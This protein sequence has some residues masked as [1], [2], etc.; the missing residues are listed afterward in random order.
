MMQDQISYCYDGQLS[1]FKA[2]N[3][4]LDRGKTPP[5]PLIRLMPAIFGLPFKT[6]G[7]YSVTFETKDQCCVPY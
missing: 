7:Q 3:T 4:G 5:K 2:L 1:H 6:E